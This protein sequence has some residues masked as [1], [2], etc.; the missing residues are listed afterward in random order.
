MEF[1]V[2]RGLVAGGFGGDLAIR[3]EEGADEGAHRE[4]VSNVA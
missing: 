4:E 3:L 2:E 1:D